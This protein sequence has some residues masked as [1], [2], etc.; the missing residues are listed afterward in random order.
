MRGAERWVTGPI[1]WGLAALVSACSGVPRDPS[2]PID[3]PWEQTNRGMLRANQVVLDPV[4]NVVKAM[5]GPLLNRVRDL[6]DNLKEPRILGNDILQGR[7]GA[8]TI[9][10]ERFVFNSIF[11]LGGLV[12]VATPGG[13]P[14]QTGDFGQTMFVWGVTAGPFVEQPYYGP[15]TLRDSFGGAVDTVADPLG[16][17]MGGVIIGWPW[18]VGSAAVSATAHLGQWKEA[19][20]ASIDFYTFLR[21]DYYQTRRGQLREALG[22]PPLTESPATGQGR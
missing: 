9:T 21:S 4:A 16:W 2:L 1:A 10:F 14:M 11:G 17:V 8:A 5:P 12:D 19:E 22:L 13:L 15:S 20:N 3:D 7:F 18:S 6:D